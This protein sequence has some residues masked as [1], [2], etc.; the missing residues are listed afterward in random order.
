[1]ASELRVN[2]LKDAAGNNSVDMTYVANVPKSW[3]YLNGVTFGVQD[4]FNTSSATDNGEG[5]Y[6]TTRTNA[7]V[8]DDYAATGLCSATSG[9]NPHYNFIVE[10][11]DN[12]TRSTTQLRTWILNPIEVNQN[13]ALDYSMSFMGDLA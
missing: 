12:R 11:Q 5:D 10:N 13:D 4:S 7:F 1:M 9:G 2:T 8:N 3:V 6:T